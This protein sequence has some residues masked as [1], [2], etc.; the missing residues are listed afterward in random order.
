MYIFLLLNT[1]ALSYGYKNIFR[2]FGA[3]DGGCVF[4]VRG[5][6]PGLSIL[7]PYGAA[8]NM[9]NLKL[10]CTVGL[11]I[12]EGGTEYCLLNTAYC[13]M[14]TID[15]LNKNIFRPSGALDGGGV[16]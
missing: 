3:L 13:Y 15:L 9:N 14:T 8:P 10:Y 1:G 11:L 5:Y 16:S 6:N 4:K 2:P 7:R 12:R